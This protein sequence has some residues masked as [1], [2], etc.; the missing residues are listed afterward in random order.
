M[1]LNNAGRDHRIK[2]LVVSHGHPELSAGGG[3]VAAYNLFRTLKR[4]SRVEKVWFVAVDHAN[5]T[6]RLVHQYENEFF[7]G[8]RT[9]DSFLMK[10][11]SPSQSVRNF[12][13]LLDFLKP[14]LINFH[15][16]IHIGTEVIQ[17]ARKI[18]PDAKIVFSLHE[19]L[20]ICPK[21]GQMVK[22]ENK[23]LCEKSSPKACGQ[24][25]PERPMEDFWLRERYFKKVFECVDYFISPSNFVKDRY[26]RWGINYDKI[27]VVENVISDLS[28]VAQEKLES[29]YLSRRIGYFGQ[30]TEYK[31]LDLLLEALTLIS[32]QVSGKL[33][34]EI[35]ASNLDIQRDQFQQRISKLLDPLVENGVVR[36]FGAYG[37]NEIAQRM[38]KVGWVIVPSIWWENSPVVIQE[39]FKLKRPVICS[40]IGGMAEKVRSGVDGV[41]FPTGNPYALAETLIS[42]CGDEILWERLRSGI[43]PPADSVLLAEKILSFDPK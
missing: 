16:F 32:H 33:V 34:V 28:P 13:K 14:D 38:G 7:W 10:S 2:V 3:E 27:M 5:P 22:G 8:N 20:A 12:S 36:W 1:E 39:A 4:S 37:R 18:C 15:H 41:H 31:G 25:F 26:V 23:I 21:D 42:L 11:I 43:S 30:A 40:D 17:I 9:G 19:M 35:H 24:C 6:N 29:R